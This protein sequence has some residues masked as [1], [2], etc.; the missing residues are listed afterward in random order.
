MLRIS[1]VRFV[2]TEGGI[3]PRRAAVA[4]IRDLF[5]VFL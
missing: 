2:L 4:P 1:F 5:E 3:D